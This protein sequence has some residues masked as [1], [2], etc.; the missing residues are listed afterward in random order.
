MKSALRRLDSAHQRLHSVISPLSPDVYSKRPTAG[1]WSVAEIVQHLCLV[2]ERVIKELEK[3]IARPPKR[4]AFLR[5]FA[6]TS[7]ISVR[8]VRVK[9]LK[10]MTPLD[11]PDKDTALANFDRIRDTLKTLCATHGVE[12]L[13]NI[14][15]KHQ[16]LGEIDGVATISFVGYHEHRHYKQIREVLKKLAAD[17]RR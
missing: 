7:L 16:V 1:E 10:A 6:P 3:A 12:R 14:V 13:R 15:F 4:V 11:A 8:L 9:A 2:E 17:S 5:R